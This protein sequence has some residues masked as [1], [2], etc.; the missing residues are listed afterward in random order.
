MITTLSIGSWNINGLGDKYRDDVFL[1]CLKYDINILLETW[2]GTDSNLNIPEFK[3]LQKCR[4]KQKR[5]KRFSGGIIILYKSKLHKGIHELSDVTT[6]Q[7]RI[8]LKLDKYFFGFQK[9]LFVCACYIPP[10]NSPYYKDDFCQLESEISQLSH[11]GNILVIGD[12]N[13]RIADKLDYIENEID[14]HDTCTL[15]NLLPEDYSCDFNIAR[16]SLDKICNNQGQQLL[17]LCIASQ[18]RVLNGRF[19]GDIMGNLTCYKSNGAS[20]VDYALADVNLMKNI[21]FFQISDP[22]YLSDH[23]QIAVHIKCYISLNYMNSHNKPNFLNYSYK[24]EGI[25]KQKLLETLGEEKTIEEIIEFENNVFQKNNPGIESAQKQLA[26]I[27]EHL[28]KRSCK[29]VKCFKKKKEG[30]N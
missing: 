22:S 27:F 19:I 30:C 21:S 17:D 14:I 7:N 25:S 6:S 13:A 4:K 11:K 24:W 20:T 15:Q 9:D 16:N 26:D 12:L 18:I 29:L 23:A 28:A 3:T 5:S 2:K 10:A 1:S 8:W